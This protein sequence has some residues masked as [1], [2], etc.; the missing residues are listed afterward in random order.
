MVS[1][2]YLEIK[3]RNKFVDM[4]VIPLGINTWR[5]N[6]EKKSGIVTIPFKKNG[7]LVLIAGSGWGK[8][9]NLKRYLDYALTLMGEGR[10]GLIIDT[11]G[12]D[13]RLMQYPNKTHKPLFVNYGEEPLQ[14]NN[15]VNYC[16]VFASNMAYEEDKVWG[17]SLNDLDSSD[18]MSSSMTKGGIIEFFK[19]KQLSNKNR[20]LLDYPNDFFMNFADL[21]ASHNDMG[22]S[23]LDY[24]NA[25]MNYNTKMSM[26]NIFSWWA[27]FEPGQEER[28]PYESKEEFNIKKRPPYFVDIEDKRYKPTFKEEWDNGKIVVN[29]FM[30]AKRE[31]EGMSIYGGY[32]L[33]NAYNYC[34]LKKKKMGKK[35]KG[36]VIVVEESNMFVDEDEKKGCN[37]YLT[38]LLCRGFKYEVS[39]IANFQSISGINKDIREHLTTGVN[40]VLIGKLTLS[41]IEMLSGIFPNIRNLKLRPQNKL[42]DNL[43]WGANEWAIY[44]NDHEYD[45]FV[46][47]PSLTKMHER[48]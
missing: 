8:S 11:Q 7:S 2:K 18:L 23:Q 15:I 45:T 27:G 34:M 12:V 19:I 25:L 38:E 30:E 9:V 3:K 14:C 4:G 10:A 16:P 42:P 44:Y 24:N 39:L 21:R 5:G 46:P 13:H 17:I 40:P 32:L 22:G 29:N 47:Y 26:M 43:Q 33:R 48:G 31:R 35:F 41:D 1:N 6:K 20:I 37:Y 28:R 36:M